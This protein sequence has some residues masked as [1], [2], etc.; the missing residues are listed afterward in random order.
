MT[1]KVFVMLLN[2]EEGRVKVFIEVK[3]TEMGDSSP[4]GLG[5]VEILVSMPSLS[6]LVDASYY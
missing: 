1:R 5:I 2:G 6:S 3:K 4:G